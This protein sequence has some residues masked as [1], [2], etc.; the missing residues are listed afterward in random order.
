MADGEK[1]QSEQRHM[2]RKQ[3]ISMY[4]QLLN[5]LGPS[6]GLQINPNEA[7]MA[8]FCLHKE[9][10]EGCRCFRPAQQICFS[11]RSIFS[12]KKTKNHPYLLFSKC[13][14]MLQ[15]QLWMIA[16]ATESGV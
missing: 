16:L 6:Q 2:E 13:T 12:D 5:V 1:E 11:I 7:A 14:V 10:R 3:Y 4:T 8:N 15:Y 9:A